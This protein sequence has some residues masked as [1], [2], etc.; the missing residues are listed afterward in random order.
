MPLFGEIVVGC[1]LASTS[2]R[3]RLHL[4]CKR[5]GLKEVALTSVI[6]WRGVFTLWIC[7]CILVLQFS[8][9]LFLL[10][11]GYKS[12]CLELRSA[13]LQ[14]C[15]LARIKARKAASTFAYLDRYFGTT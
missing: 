7:F 6:A 15:V 4:I 13:A 8:R 11:L 10:E 9:S 1:V 5:I 12:A 3:A 14:W 2:C